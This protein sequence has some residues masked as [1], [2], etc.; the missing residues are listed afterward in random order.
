[1][2]KGVSEVTL[3]VQSRSK[4]KRKIV[5]TR[6][7][8]DWEITSPIKTPGDKDAI[9]GLAGSVLAAKRIRV[10]VESVGK[11]QQATK[12]KKKVKANPLAIYG[13]VKPGFIASVKTSK[14]KTYEL[15]L[16]RKNPFDSNYFAST[17]AGKKVV[18]VSSSIYYALNK[19]LF[20]LRNKK[21]FTQKT[22]EIKTLRISRKD[23]LLSFQRR[24]ESTPTIKA[25]RHAHGHGHGHGHGKTPK[26]KDTWFMVTPLATRADT[27]KL[28]SLLSTLKFLQA[29]EFVSE[30]SKKDAKKFG[31]ANPD[32][33]VEV[34][35]KDG[36]SMALHFGIKGKGSSRK[37]YVASSAGGPIAKISD[38]AVKALEKKADHF[39]FKNVVDIDRDHVHTVKITTGSETFKIGR[40]A[41]KGTWLVFAP[42]PRKAVDYKATNLL[43]A[44][45]NLKCDRFVKEGADKAALALYG[46]DKPT[47][48]FA[49]VS[50]N[51]RTILDL[52]LVGKADASGYFVTNK[53]RK[54]IFHVKK[55]DLDAVPTASWKVIKG[56]KAPKK[57]ARPVV[58]K[59]VVRKTLPRP[60]V[61]PAP[62]PAAKPAPSKPAPKPA[63]KPAPAKPAMK[64]APAKPA[65][66]P[67]VK[68]APAKPAPK[69]AVKPVPAKP[70]PKPAVKPAPAKP[71]PKPA[72]KPAPA[73]P[74]PKP[75]VKPAPAKPAPTPAVKPAP[76]KPAP[77]PAV[78]PVPAK[79]AAKPAPAKPTPPKAPPAA[80][81]ASRPV[82]GK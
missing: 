27:S 21:L 5:A 10:A 34:A 4:G 13:L 2:L 58:K 55:K 38:H 76:A 47:K 49:F 61:K 72:V 71:A 74:A 17:A 18:V 82:Q 57:K 81:P 46:L 51:G 6:K 16:G 45:S 15:K 40:G 78:K 12:G 37:V 75:A 69:P 66:K 56:G 60:A 53:A 20:D 23:A 9:E 42:A 64:P 80:P 59:P 28:T 33:K 7:G 11:K 25:K 35:L 67:A 41:K 70:A 30:S 73:K 31:L 62:K 19:K 54:T 63:V 1:M 48:T 29:T 44:L 14:G 3:F 32:I 65:P 43:Y 68:P 22:K 79:P 50:P 24:W 36:L 26:S 77:K 52:L 39:R 8:D